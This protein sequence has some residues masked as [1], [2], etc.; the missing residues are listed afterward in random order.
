MTE[1]LPL[2][3]QKKENDAVRGFLRGYFAKEIM[4]GET[5]EVVEGRVDA[6]IEHLGAA[7][8]I[9]PDPE[10]EALC[11][12]LRLTRDLSGAQVLQAAKDLYPQYGLGRDA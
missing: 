6:V 9:T 11:A 5:R 4:T 12:D 10:S 3:A 7:D 1:T 2:P 8:G